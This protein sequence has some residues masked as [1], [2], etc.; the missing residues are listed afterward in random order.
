MRTILIDSRKRGYQTLKAL[1][2]AGAETAGVVSL[3]QHAHETEN[4][5]QA[6]CDLT[7]E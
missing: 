1:L 2:E 5:E 7:A 4:Y 6:F 3:A